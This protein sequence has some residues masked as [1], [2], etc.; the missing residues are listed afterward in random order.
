MQNT[1]NKSKKFV[2]LATYVV[3]VL[4]LLA[5][6]FAPIFNGKNILALQLPEAFKCLVNKGSTDAQFPF[7]LSYHISLFGIEKLSF[8]FMALIVVL[9]SIITALAVLGF[10]P[11]AFSVR[12]EGK[13][14][15][16]VYY[17]IEIA[18]VIILTIYGITVAFMLA[19]NKGMP[20]YASL[21]PFPQIAN[22]SAIG[23][24]ML[25][26]LGGTVIALVALCI[27]DKGKSSA[28]KIVFFV[29]SVLGVLCLLNFVVLM[30]KSIEFG[31]FTDKIGSGLVS[32]SA[33]ID[34]LTVLFTQ[35][36]SV[37]LANT[38][39]KFKLLFYFEAITSILVLANFFID[40]V[41]LATRKD[42]KAG[43]IFNVTRYTLEFIC[44]ICV[45]II[46][47]VCKQPIGLM[48][49][50]LSAAVAVQLII[51]AVRLVTSILRKPETQ[52]NVD[53]I[54]VIDIYDDVMQPALT[55]ETKDEYETQE[56]VFDDGYTAPED[57]GYVL[58][59]N[60]CGPIEQPPVDEPVEETVSEQTEEQPAT[61]EV[62]RETVDEPAETIETEEEITKF[63]EEEDTSYLIPSVE[64]QAE[65]A[66]Q[67]EETEEVSEKVTEETETVAEP[68]EQPAEE[69][70]D[71]VT[72]IEDVKEPDQAEQPDETTQEETVQKP[73]REDVK[74]YN[75]YEHNNNPF[76]AYEQSSQPVQP[77]NPY[78]QHKTTVYEPK[79][80]KPAEKTE[81]VQAK[82][83]VK[84]YEP[85]VEKQPVKP[86]QPRPIIQEFKPVP[87]V[88]EQPQPVKE[89]NVYTIDT[90]YA[91]PSDTFIRKLTNDEKIEFARTFIEKNRGDLGSI[92]DYVVGGDN[93]KFFSVAFI[94][95]GRIRG[96]ISDGLLN[97]MFKE[98]NML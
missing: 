1:E 48:L 77:Y 71:E 86:L 82:P 29:L 46:A 74:P 41:K 58:P 47:L 63:Y 50:A 28:L 14:A 70:V 89:T 42:R 11:V 25:I 78:A 88:S 38:E 5:G 94:Y 7:T 9:Y 22:F 39:T 93:K 35:K 53:E 24:N 79:I 36:L 49:I 10:I 80:Q 45:L 60:D 97:K 66:E 23:Y 96:L 56:N 69:I 19:A 30:S 8:D 92:P 16:K 26:A 21:I 15:K 83:I 33:G 85:P 13:A 18:A 59:E 73:Y 34:A 75:P 32:S 64:E 57:D 61:E 44:A 31:E 20:P 55:D 43:L 2:V 76:R 6:L 17:C 67:P 4:C 62:A 27:S 12:K 98:L 87:P 65:Q 37:I 40:T 54:D 68:Q 51:T 90:V 3:A 95:L 91:G 84:P 81:P 72:E 52:R